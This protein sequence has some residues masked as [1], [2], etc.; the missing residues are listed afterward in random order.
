MLLLRTFLDR[1]E[2]A[3][4]VRRLDL[5][6]EGF[7]IRPPYLYNTQKPIALPNIVTLSTEK[8]SQIAKYTTNSPEIINSWIHEAQS[9]SSDA[10]AGFLISL[11]PNLAWL[12]FSEDWTNEVKYI[13]LVFG[14]ATYRTF[15]DSFQPRLPTYESL[16]HI[17]LPLFIDE[18]Y[19]LDPPNTPDALSLFYVPKI[20]HLSVSISNPVEFSWPSSTPPNPLFLSSLD[21]GRI[22]EVRL[23]PLLSVL[24]NLQK[25]R[26]NWYYQEN[27]D[28]KVSDQI[29]RLDTMA[30]A[31]AGLS[32][33]LTEL[34]ITADSQ[35]AYSWGDYEP[36]DFTLQGSLEQISQLHRVTRLHVPWLFVMGMT[37]SS[38]GRIGPILPPNV[39]DL[40]LTG[41]LCITE[42]HEWDDEM[43]VSAIKSE[44]ESGA[45]ASVENLK[46]M[47]VLGSCY[48]D[49]TTKECQ[50]D[51]KD[52]GIRF[53][54]EIVMPGRHL[55]EKVEH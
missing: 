37:K 48:H 1:P 52:L 47:T 55:R 44:L 41:H 14:S 16:K 30:A 20:E 21:L 32:G 4:Y 54:V 49:G 46:K 17:K 2:L 11:M 34:E 6:G 28:R 43:V 42:A 5:D 12:S 9:G 7:R 15:E 23:E 36:P 3:S 13:G 39:E 18:E 19:Y 8:L 24:K 29:V 53:N 51:L 40:A 26:Y 31:L 50:K 25:L 45:L 10:V 27:L 33:T 38:P 22:R 35:P